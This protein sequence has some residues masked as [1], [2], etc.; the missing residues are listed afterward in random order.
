MI[1]SK[2]KLVIACLCTLFIFSNSLNIYA[3]KKN[4]NNSQEE[5]ASVAEVKKES[6]TKQKKQKKKDSEQTAEKPKKLTAAEKKAKKQEEKEA[7]KLA[8]EQKKAQLESESKDILD[9]SR[10]KIVDMI[11]GE[12]VFTAEKNYKT[13]GNI[14]LSVKGTVGTFQFYAINENKQEIPLLVGYD[15]STSSFFS[16]K[17]GKRVFKLND[18]TG[19]IIGSR[20]NDNGVQLVYVVPDV[21]RIFV[22]YNCIKSNPKSNE[23]IIKITATVLNLGSKKETFALKNV[24]DTVLGEQSGP[25]FMTAEDRNINTECQFRKFDGIKWISSGN[26]KA[27]MQILL[28]GADITKPEVVTLSNKDILALN[29]WIPVEVKSRSFDSVLSY[30]NS[31]VCINWESVALEPKEEAA[32]IYYIA[33]ATDGDFP[34]GNIFLKKY[35]E[36]HA[37]EKDL[38][39]V[40]KNTEQ[41]TKIEST[42]EKSN[43][44]HQLS[45]SQTKANSENKSETVDKENS[46]EKND[47]NS[48]KNPVF[49]ISPESIT[50][51]QL[52]SAYIQALIDKINSLEKNSATIDRME[53]LR[54]NTELDA[55]LRKLEQQ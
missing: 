20:K 32:F 24:L 2:R 43:Q 15:E 17:V 48:S 7:R 16:L 13:V 41:K 45:I 46:V 55:I 19:I 14:K 26:S 52:D 30:N 53:L 4:K 10:I 23:D 33:I 12:G 31:A 34:R 3:A 40:S 5:T 47:E 39:S 8:S 21:A 6:K 27:C 38:N 37:S 1:F 29:N 9:K 50:D 44:N 35:E 18:N 54:L 49:E 11:G 22:K 36:E 51:S 28:N 25:H 42:K